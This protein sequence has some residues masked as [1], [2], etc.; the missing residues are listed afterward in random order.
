VPPPLTLS[1]LSARR[2]QLRA[3]GLDQPFPAI[4]AALEHLGYVQID[5]LNI[6]GRMHDLILRH[7]VAGYREGDLMRHL[8]EDGGPSAVPRAASHRI[9]FEHHHPETHIL[10]AFPLEAWPHLLG[11]M[12]ARSRTNSAWS[13]RLTPTERKLAPRLLAEIEARGPLGSEEFNDARKAHRR[14]WGAATLVKST[15]QKL[16]FHGELLIAERN[17]HRRRYDL[18]RRVLPSE[19]LALPQA[20]AA[21]AARWIALLKLR[22]RRLVT[23]K[24]EELRV[25]DDAVQPVHVDGCPSLYC[26]KQDLALLDECS[27]GGDDAE[28]E[29]VGAKSQVRF[30]APLDPLIYDRRIT[31]ALWDFDYTWEAYT[32][33]AKRVRG[34]YALPVLV[35]TELVGHVEPRADRVCGK[36]NVA[37]RALRRG[38]RVSGALD[39]FAAWL[40]LRR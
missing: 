34:H 10:V 31:R 11:A 3:L 4:Q 26:L 30:L 12:R 32:P 18:P 15:L 25:A 1:K 24:R 36:L 5:P 23:L 33:A 17:K 35:G 39:E 14:V 16:F 19:I 40:G 6:C 27:A 7:R 13:G 38:Y 9:A 29:P 37:S 2:F 20:P 22:Q 28:R 8:H 21:E